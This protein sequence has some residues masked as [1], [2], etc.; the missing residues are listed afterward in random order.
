[1]PLTSTLVI[2]AVLSRCRKGRPP[3]KV[4][5]VLNEQLEND[6]TRYLPGR[7]IGYSQATFFVVFGS[8]RGSDTGLALALARRIP[9][10]CPTMP[11]L[12]HRGVTKLS[13]S[14]PSGLNSGFAACHAGP[15]RAQLPC[16]DCLLAAA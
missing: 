7:S 11:G 9:G 6:S 1:M 15:Q 13:C 5:S 4:S 3:Q 10:L 12:M 2:E 14:Q 8:P 16:H